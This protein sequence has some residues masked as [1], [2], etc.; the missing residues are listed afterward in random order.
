MMI[1]QNSE[2][3]LGLI[4]WQLTCCHPMRNILIPPGYKYIYNSV[5]YYI[6]TIKVNTQ[7]INRIRIGRS[8][9]QIYWKPLSQKRKHQIKPFD[10]CKKLS[11]YW[12]INLLLDIYHRSMYYVCSHISLKQKFIFLYTIRGRTQT[13]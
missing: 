1:S 11:L 13:T 7:C 4:K 12:Q 3:I 2:T 10:S 9:D 8:C 6:L 5:L